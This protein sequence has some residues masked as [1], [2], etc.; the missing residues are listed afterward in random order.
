MMQVFLSVRLHH[1][2]SPATCF[3]DNPLPFG[4][5]GY[6]L[7]YIATNL[8][9]IHSKQT[10]R[11]Y[12]M[13]EKNQNIDEM[14]IW[15]DA[16]QMLRKAEKENIETAW[17][18]LQKQTPHCQFGE[19]GICCRICTMGPCRI[20][21]KASRG[22]CGADA[23]VI[24]A[25]NFGRFITGGAAGHSDH[26]RDCIEALHAVA[27]GETKDYEIKDKEKLLRIAEEVGI[28]TNDRDYLDV[29]K[30]LAAEFFENY[31]T[32][33]GA[34]SFASRVPEKRKELWSSLGIT[35]RGVDREIAEMM[36]RTHMGCDNDA[37]QHH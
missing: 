15:E 22:V 31:G 32:T 17:D 27:H 20:G 6:Y 7:H 19:G 36:H 4:I 9:P 2:I 26:G 24:V 28:N 18:R 34:V 14:T 3:A 16:K 35:P 10:E 23:D 8:C 11:G 33:K 12:K 13:P 30:D 1:G 25:R 29:A 5:I 21:K 37:H